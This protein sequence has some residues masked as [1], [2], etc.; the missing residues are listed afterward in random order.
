VRHIF[1]S[2]SL[3]KLQPG[4]G[5]GSTEVTVPAGSVREA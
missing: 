4:F 3:I 2:V 1:Q 5:Q